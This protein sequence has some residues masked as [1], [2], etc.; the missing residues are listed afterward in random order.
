MG[1]S[2]MLKTLQTN[3][4]SAGPPSACPAGHLLMPN[5]PLKYQAKAWHTFRQGFHDSRSPLVAGPAK[6]TSGT[7]SH[8]NLLISSPYSQSFQTSEKATGLQTK[9]QFMSQLSPQR[10]H[11]SFISASKQV[12]RI[13]PANLFKR[14]HQ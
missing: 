5:T 7:Q 8:Q 14:C 4:L 1:S 10:V 6:T 11:T 13:T 12:W 9:M 3:G 2:F